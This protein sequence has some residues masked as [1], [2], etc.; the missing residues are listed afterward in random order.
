MK[1][2]LI[3]D[4]ESAPKMT[5][6]TFFVAPSNRLAAAT[7]DNWE[8]WPSS[9]LV[10]TGPKGSGKTHLTHIWAEETG[11][12]ILSA[13]DLESTDI[14]S[15]CTGPIAVEDIPAIAGNGPAED[16]LFHLHNLCLANGH[17]LLMTGVE[18]PLR[19]G[20]LL[21]DLLSRLQ[22]T[23]SIGLDAPDD[24]LLTAVLVKLLSDQQINS[25]PKLIAYITK[26][27]ERSFEAAHNLIRAL[28]QESLSKSKPLTLKLAADV[29]DRIA[30]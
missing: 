14:Q 13:R 26:R 24:T 17:A 30:D 5:R 12:T 4:L 9:K 29:L 7:V 15:I 16:A 10:L 11:A 1:Q 25:D 21:P 28:D 20:I 18:A 22:G 8:N 23:T 27:M 2:Q 3:F 6:D 19:W